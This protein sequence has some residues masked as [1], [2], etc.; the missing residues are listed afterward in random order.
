MMFRCLRAA[1]ASLPLLL[2]AGCNDGLAKVS[3][4]VTLDDKP[5][6]G[7]EEFLGTVTFTSDV[8]RAA[9][10]GIIDSSGQYTL[11]TGS[12]KGIAPGTYLVGV[13]VRKITPA[14]DIGGLPKVT[15]VSP[16]KYAVP[17]TSGLRQEVKAGANTCNFALTSDKK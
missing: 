17:A 15:L 7:S 4:K 1:A 14:A 3:G 12:Q 13:E 10:T 11:R 6:V 9:G 8:G 2:F 16:K 5:V